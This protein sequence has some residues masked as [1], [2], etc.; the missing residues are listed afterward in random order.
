MLIGIFLAILVLSLAVWEILSRWRKYRRLRLHG[1]LVQARVIDI[2]REP[3][4]LPAGGFIS[5]YGIISPVQ[6]VKY[7]D[8]LYAQWRDPSTQQVYLFRAKIPLAYQFHTGELIM[9]RMNSENPLQY[10]IQFSRKKRTVRKALPHWDVPS[11]RDVQERDLTSMYEIPAQNDEEQPKA[12][13]PQ[14]LPEQKNS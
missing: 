2:K 14:Q 1:M 6:Q 11:N 9:V 3:R 10:H 8:F 4:V 13:Y 5:A 7:E 12:S